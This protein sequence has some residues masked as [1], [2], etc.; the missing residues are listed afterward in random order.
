MAT[1]HS[2]GKKSFYGAQ[3]KNLNEDRPILSA[4]KCRSM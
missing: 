1:T 4:A 2:F 3:Q